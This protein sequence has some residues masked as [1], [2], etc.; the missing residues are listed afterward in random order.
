MS[1]SDI[2][3]GW[4]LSCDTAPSIYGGWKDAGISSAPQSTAAATPH[5][6]VGRRS[7]VSLPFPPLLC[8]SDSGGR[9]GRSGRAGILSTDKV[10]I[11]NEGK[12]DR[13]SSGYLPRIPPREIFWQTALVFTS[14]SLINLTSIKQRTSSQTG[15]GF[16][17]EVKLPN[18]G[19]V[20]LEVNDG[21][22]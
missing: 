20:A 17:G 3:T 8:Q 16:F 6:M 5:C 10:C 14:A 7:N 15:A 21:F 1:F 22:A 18:A 11:V 13:S 19:P 2:T 4:N 12:R 9:V